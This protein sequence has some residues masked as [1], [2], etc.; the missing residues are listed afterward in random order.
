M[1]GFWDDPETYE[2]CPKYD[3]DYFDDDDTS[4]DDEATDWE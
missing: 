2:E 3:E 1:P 4:A